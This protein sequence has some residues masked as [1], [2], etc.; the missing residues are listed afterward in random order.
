MLNSYTYILELIIYNNTKNIKE[1][2]NSVHKSKKAKLNTNNNNT[3]GRTNYNNQS[4]TI[5]ME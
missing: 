4:I 2:N 1:N 5:L 3:K